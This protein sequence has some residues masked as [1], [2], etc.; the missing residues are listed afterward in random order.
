MNKEGKFI[1]SSG[2]ASLSPFCTAFCFAFPAVWVGVIF[3]WVGFRGK[4]LRVSYLS[5]LP[6]SLCISLVKVDDSFSSCDLLLFHGC[7]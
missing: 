7:M 6:F 2:L 4:V 5:F 3:L 1:L